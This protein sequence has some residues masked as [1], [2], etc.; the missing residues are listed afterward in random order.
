MKNFFFGFGFQVFVSDII[1]G[2]GFRA[3]WLRLPTLGTN[4]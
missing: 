1:G 3:F 2:V 4:H